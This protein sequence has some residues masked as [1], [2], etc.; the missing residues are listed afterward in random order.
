MEHPI[1]INSKGEFVN[2]NNW[3]GILGKA[4]IN[5]RGVSQLAKAMTA[6]IRRTLDYQGI[7]RKVLLVQPLDEKK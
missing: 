7:A 1:V 5:V 3:G 6:P 2:K 4:F